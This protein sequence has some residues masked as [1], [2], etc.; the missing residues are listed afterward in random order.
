[1]VVHDDRGPAGPGVVGHL[2]LPGAQRRGRLV[3]DAGGVQAGPTVGRHL[4]QRGDL[5]VLGEQDRCGDPLRA[6]ETRTA[7]GEVLRCEPEL[8][9][10]HEQVAELVPERR[11]REGLRGH[12]RGPPHRGTQAEPVTLEQLTEDLV[13]LRTGDQG[14]GRLVSERRT[15]AQH[16][17]SERGGRP[18]EDLSR[19]P[20]EP[21]RDGVPDPGCAAAGGHEQQRALLPGHGGPGRGRLGA[22]PGE[23]D[24]ERRRGLARPR[25][26]DDEEVAGAGAPR[27]GVAL[28][29]VQLR[30]AGAG[31]GRV[32]RG[33]VLRVAVSMSTM[34]PQPTDIRVR[35]HGAPRVTGPARPSRWAGSRRGR[36]S[37][38]PSPARPRP[39]RGR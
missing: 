24:L 14:G 38:G 19:G 1:M 4:P 3:D 2:A 39:A 33:P 34:P 35:R 37:A 15:Q 12:C 17:V 7:C 27:D 28:A 9:G 18:D 13:L 5:L 30:R 8:S 22:R 32:R 29:R 25:G 23:E 11:Q 21:G 16:R 26:P 31:S 20:A 10:A 36:C 6:V